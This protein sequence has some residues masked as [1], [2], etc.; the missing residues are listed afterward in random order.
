MRA[1]WLRRKGADELIVVLGG[2]AAGAA[3][4]S[5][6][7]GAADVLLLSDYRRLD[8]PDWPAGYAAM[9]LVAWS[10]GVAA[11]AQLPGAALA[12]F[13]RRLAVCGS[14]APCDDDLGI[15]RRMVQ[16]TAEG[17]SPDSLRQFGR[18]AGCAMPEEAD[19]GAL[20][21]ELHAVLDWPMPAWPAFDRVILGRRDRV[22]PPENL[23]RAWAGQ[24]AVRVLDCGHNPFALWRDWDEAW[25]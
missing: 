18:R 25:I 16:A 15:P 8:P 1:E 3:P 12:G 10:F 6:L 21:A 14:W 13:R 24:G 23:A 22:F 17:L 11:A 9:D 4:F 20:C 5:H 19:I 7:A 2:W